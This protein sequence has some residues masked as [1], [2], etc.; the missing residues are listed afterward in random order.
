MNITQA[1]KLNGML[2]D[3]RLSYLQICQIGMQVIMINFVSST[4]AIFP[5]YFILIL[6]ITRKERKKKGSLD[7]FSKKTIGHIL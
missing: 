4:C 2:Y 5:I 3:F 7:N 6:D 1:F